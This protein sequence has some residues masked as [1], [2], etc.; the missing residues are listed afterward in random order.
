[1]K[2]RRRVSVF[3]WNAHNCSVNCSL[4]WK[5]IVL[6]SAYCF[7]LPYFRVCVYTLPPS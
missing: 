4:V 3:V 6:I 7:K 5:K 2:K 1:M